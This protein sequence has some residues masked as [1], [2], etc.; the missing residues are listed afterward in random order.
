M[1]SKI[2]LELIDVGPQVVEKKARPAGLGA[3]RVARG[4]M[5]QTGGLP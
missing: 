5:R 3:A 4:A 1:Y 2:A